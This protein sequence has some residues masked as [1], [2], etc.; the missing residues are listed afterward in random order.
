MKVTIEFDLDKLPD[1]C[2]ECPIH[3]GED[4]RCIIDGR[5]SEWRPFWCPLKVMPKETKPYYG[6]SLGGAECY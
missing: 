5:S 4:G 3:N 2:D 6:D 1:R